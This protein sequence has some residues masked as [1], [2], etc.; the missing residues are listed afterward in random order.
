M[1]LVFP[2]THTHTTDYGIPSLRVC[3]SER[4]S[5][6]GERRKRCL[7]FSPPEEK[8]WNHFTPT[9]SGNVYR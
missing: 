8:N 7:V 6:E 4:D 3:D 1:L 2:V 9:L 5:E